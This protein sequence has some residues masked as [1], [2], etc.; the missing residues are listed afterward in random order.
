VTRGADETNPLAGLSG[1]PGASSAGSSGSG[2][3]AVKPSRHAA[4]ADDLEAAAAVDGAVGYG[5]M[6]EAAWAY[7]LARI[8]TRR[9]DLDAIF[10]SV[11]AADA[12]ATA[13]ASLADSSSEDAV[14]VLACGPDALVDHVS[15]LC[16]AHRF[17][18][19]SERFAY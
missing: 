13:S 12:S 7:V 15:D 16:F 11:A 4:A 9:P 3:S 14:A 10:A 6:S 17:A 2:N 8:Q 18:F 5:D 1:G 19:H